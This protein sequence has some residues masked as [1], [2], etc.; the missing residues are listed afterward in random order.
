MT[1]LRKAVLTGCLRISSVPAEQSE[2]KQ[3]KG[4]VNLGDG[5]ASVDSESGRGFINRKGVGSVN[6]N[7]AI[8]CRK[9]PAV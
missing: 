8:E 3:G 4:M 1:Q 5:F 2:N 7:R 9:L 6:R